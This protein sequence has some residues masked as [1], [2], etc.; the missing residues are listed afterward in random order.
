MLGG[1]NDPEDPHQAQ[2]PQEPQVHTDQEGDV[3]RYDGEKVNN[4]VK[5]KNIPYRIVFMSNQPHDVFN[6]ENGNG[7]KFEQVK[8][9]PVFQCEGFNG[10]QQ[11]GNNVQ[12]DQN[13]DGCVEYPGINDIFNHTLE[14][15]KLA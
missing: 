12:N 2:K 11:N 9:L 14:G 10:F 1:L 8:E 3:E 6:G 7:N 13:Q 15:I 4:G 5:G